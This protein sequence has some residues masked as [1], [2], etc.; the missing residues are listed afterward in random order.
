M[1]QRWCWAATIFAA[2]DLI[3]GDVFRFFCLSITPLS[4]TYRNLCFC[5]LF[6][7]LK[8]KSRPLSHN[9]R[10]PT[11]ERKRESQA[12]VLSMR[13]SSFFW[14]RIWLPRNYQQIWWLISDTAVSPDASFLCFEGFF[15]SFG[16]TNRILVRS[17]PKSVRL[18][19]ETNIFPGMYHWVTAVR[20]CLILL[21]NLKRNFL[22]NQKIYWKNF[23]HLA[24]H[25]LIDNVQS[26][27]MFVVS[28]RPWRGGGGGGKK[29][30][31]SNVG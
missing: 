15:P 23:K 5:W 25:P 18:W 31:P 4:F 17:A 10:V 13:F 27:W 9:L 12:S 1:C 16:K 7:S 8:W 14:H 2:T 29:S 22:G 6:S 21:S 19:R 28:Q 20:K 24:Y 3:R 30:T 26:V 11:F